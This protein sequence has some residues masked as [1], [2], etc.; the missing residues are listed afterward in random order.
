MYGPFAMS[1]QLK[2]AR[3][4]QVTPVILNGSGPVPTDLRHCLDGRTPGNDA[5]TSLGMRRRRVSGI[6]RMV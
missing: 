1:L 5:L 3:S 6:S 2:F 4:Q